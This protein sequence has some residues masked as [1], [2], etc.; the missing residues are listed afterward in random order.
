MGAAGKT[1]IDLGAELNVDAVAVGGSL[2]AC[3]ASR[4]TGRLWSGAVVIGM[5]VLFVFSHTFFFLCFPSL[6][7]ESNQPP[8]IICDALRALTAAVF[9]PIE[10]FLIFFLRRNA[11]PR[12]QPPLTAAWA[13]RRHQLACARWRASHPREA[14]P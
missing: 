10:R 14:A 1:L 11:N 2:V 8:Q 12:I 7:V 3:G 5:G 13:A 9:I 4:L 6:V